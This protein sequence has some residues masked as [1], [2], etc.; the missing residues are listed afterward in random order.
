VRWS[1]K[2]KSSA[3]VYLTILHVAAAAVTNPLGTVL[4]LLDEL[5]TK[6]SHDGEVEAAAY[7]EYVEWCDDTSK[8]TEYAIDTATKQKAKLEAQIGELTSEIQVAGSKIDDLASSVATATKD[9]DNAA[10]IRGKEAAD[11]S[12]SENELM[13]AISALTRATG[14]LEKEMS[15]NP[16]SF[17]Q[18]DTSSVSS[19]LQALSTVLN[20]AALSSSNQKTLLALAQSQSSDDDDLGEPSAAVYKTH[21]NNIF[22][23]LEDLKE[24]AES[25]LSDLRKA[26]VNTKHNYELLK[27]SLEDQAAADTKAKDEQQADKASAEEAKATSE[28]DLEMTSKSLASSQQQLATAHATCLQVAADH[29]TTVAA[30]VEELKVLAQA[31]KILGDTSSGAVSQTYSFVQVGITGG[32][33]LETRADLIG[34]E[35]VESVKQLAKQQHSATLAQLASQLA[36]VV[37]FGAS[38]GEDPFANITGLIRDMISK[39]EKEA[40]DEATEKAY[41]DEQITKTESKQGELEEDIAK[42]TSRIDQ[43]AARSAQLKGEIT[44]LEAE[45]ASLA[46]EQAEIDKIR[47]E[48]HED[49]SQAKSDLELGLSGV[50]KA[51]SLLRDYYGSTASMLQDDQS[52]FMQQPTMPETH[53]KSGGAGG[54]IVDILEVC[55]SDFATNLAK[56]ETQE[57]DAQSTY[58]KVSQ[59]NAVTKTTKD[60]DVKYKTQES[61]SMDA[62]VT[63]YSGD[64]DSSNA[65][66]SAVLEYY[67]KINE[68]CIAKPEK[69]EE[70]KRR[71]ES[72]ITGLQSALTVLREQT[73][74]VQRKQHSFRGSLEAN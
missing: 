7:H 62:T 29:E 9:A 39:L 50:R 22:D 57:A 14:V 10:L 19:T 67:S 20:A 43:S 38:N 66:L 36:A 4:S 13:D 46:K 70:R 23:V 2:M 41:C 44:E 31:K 45:L 59:D 32:L 47:M 65:E 58:E 24:K 63:E 71:R 21:S 35:V 27:Q 3:L 72:E 60:Q 34:S 5:S 16:A 56:E 17:A 40:G 69:Y 48:T 1:L 26:E 11:F 52:A 73:A 54:S 37:R 61:K 68:R 64:R 53:S 6:I 15:K 33:R 74:L 49:Y 42:M 8:N 55:E 51:L 30:R 12:A 28:G 25:Q 18:L